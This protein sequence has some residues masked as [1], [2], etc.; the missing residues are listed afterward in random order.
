MDDYHT[1]SKNIVKINKVADYLNGISQKCENQ[2]IFIK[3]LEKIDENNISIPTIYNYN[4]VIKYNYNIQ[5]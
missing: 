3:K 2:I 1:P 5:Q 4:N